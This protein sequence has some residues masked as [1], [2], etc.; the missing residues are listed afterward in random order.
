MHIAIGYKDKLNMYS[1][2]GKLL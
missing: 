2:R 1:C